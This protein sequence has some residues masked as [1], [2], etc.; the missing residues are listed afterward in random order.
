MAVIRNLVVKIGADISGLSKGLMSAQ[1]HLLKVSKQMER[2][3]RNLTAKITTPLVGFAT[4]AVTATSK[5]ED[6]LQNISRG[7]SGTSEEVERLTNL[8][9]KMSR[10]T[11]GDI[12][13]VAGAMRELQRAGFSV[14]QMESSLVTI[15][16]LATAAGV[17][18][19]VATEG[20]VKVLSQFN[21]EAKDTSKVTNSMAA[22][23]A[24]ST[25]TFDELVTGL[26]LAGNVA[27]SFGYSVEEVSAALVELTNA[28]YESKDA[29]SYLKT[30]LLKLESPTSDMIKKLDEL[31]LTVEDISPATHS[32]AEI[33]KTFEKANIKSADATSLF[34]KDLE[35]VFMTL[36][37]D[38]SD[39]LENLTQKMSDTN[40]AEDEAQKKLS[41]LSGQLKQIK[42]MLSEIA[43]QFGEVLIPKVKAFLEKYIMPL[44]NKFSKLSDKSKNLI[45]KIGAIAAAIGPVILIIGKLTKSFSAISGV[46]GALSGPVG[47]VLAV[48]AALA[49]A[50]ITLYKNNEDFRNRV[51]AIWEKI[52]GIL[53]SVG[54][55]I[56]DFWDSCGK[57]LLEN[58]SAVF[59]AIFR[60][61]FD[62]VEKIIEI[63]SN[64]WNK[65]VDLWNN[66]EKFRSGVESIWNSIMKIIQTTAELIVE[67][68]DKYG[69]RLLEVCGKV[70]NTIFE[71]VSTIFQ[72]LVVIFQKLFD[73]IEPIWD[74]LCD[75]ILTIVDVV[76]TVLEFLEPILKVI[77]ELVGWLVDVIG[78]AIGTIIDCFGPFIDAIG[79][80]LQIVSHVIQ[81]IVAL[82]KGDFTGAFEHMKIVGTNLGD[83]F[84][85]LFTGIW[86]LA[87]GF[88]S[89]MC[90]I[91]VSLGTKLGEICSGIFKTVGG[92]FSSLWD[93]IKSTAN[94]IWNTMTGVFGRIGDWFGNLFTDAFNWGKN[95]IHMIGD[96]I[97][98]A[99]NWIKDACSSVIGTIKGWLGFG[100]PTEEGPGR[101]SDEWAP[102]LMKMY[103][104]GIEA[105]IPDIQEAVGEVA[106]AISSLGN[107]DKQVVSTG[108][109]SLSADILNGLMSA[110]SF[111]QGKETTTEQPIELS[112]DGDKF[113]RL[114]VPSIKSE[115]KRNG[116][117][118]KEGGF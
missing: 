18:Y 107:E 64:L 100:S 114:I 87:K 2:V 20:V 14:E 31:G 89:T 17:E 99:G 59:L 75:L 65:L 6:A 48:V 93:G 30:I 36:V 51:K 69:A 10:S 3:G 21:L 55:A 110:F 57:E 66:N 39:S 85:N 8:A 103:A 115:L 13:K 108:D 118:L 49:A 38:G 73:A 29:G 5:V 62:V 106:S 105:N 84:K 63:L 117:I 7:F 41:T 43:L 80:I 34:G 15:S 112:I 54:T 58:L 4:L 78:D 16:N 12:T 94:G 25:M 68:W 74:D 116:I 45:I 113:A 102:N 81:A 40:A 23:L 19:E 67:I 9:K 46:L 92:W 22:A 47:I 53:V 71:V 52:K 44:I 98:A 90:N 33:I 27:S 32:L 83:F 109:T 60:V 97:K 42:Q 96:G 26:G 35:A 1:K 24:N 91:F 56:K 28:G 88:V 82:F 61:I 86:D 101:Y 95:L 104:E 72:A 11:T 111:M 50:F 37:N 70:F 77:A 79:N 76:T